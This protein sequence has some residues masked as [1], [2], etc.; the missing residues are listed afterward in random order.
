M[1][2][3]DNFIKKLSSFKYPIYIKNQFGIV[4]ETVG[5]GYKFVTFYC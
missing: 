1:L 3:F 4:V 5:A 2:N